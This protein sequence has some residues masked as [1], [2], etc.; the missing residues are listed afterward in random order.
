LGV[1][2]FV[3][4]G[5]EDG[6][7]GGFGAGVWLFFGLH[8]QHALEEPA[9]H[10]FGFCGF[11]DIGA[12]GEDAEGRVDDDLFYGLGFS[13]GS[14]AELG[15][16]KV[17]A[18]DL[19]AVEEKA[20]AAWV[21]I[22]GGD[23]LEDFADGGLNGGAVLWEW[24][25]EG[26][27]AASALFWISDGAARGVVVVAEFLVA[28]ADA[29][30]AVTVGE[31]VTALEALWRFGFGDGVVHVPPHW[32]KSVQSVQKK[33]PEPVLPGSGLCSCG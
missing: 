23:A 4:G 28:Q 1:V 19:E 12:W 8:S 33:R 10:A 6:D 9:D 17:K 31:D 15:F 29:A 3:C 18:G 32:V 14:C 20:G 21:D 27:A 2:E 5:V 30:A 16:G 22:I 7:G 26:G 11:G 24:Q 13:G 25:V